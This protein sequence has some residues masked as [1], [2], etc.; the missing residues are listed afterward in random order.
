MP[1]IL[2]ENHRK[3]GTFYKEWYLFTLTFH[4][5]PA[6]CTQKYFRDRL[7]SFRKENPE[8]GEFLNR[9]QKTIIERKLDYC[10]NILLFLKGEAKTNWISPRN[11]L[12]RMF[13]KLFNHDFSSKQAVNYIEKCHDSYLFLLN[14]K[15]KLS[16][17]YEVYLKR[18]KLDGSVIDFLEISL[19]PENESEDWDDY[20]FID[21]IFGSMQE[22]KRY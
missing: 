11:S 13:I 1:P 2:C 18:N 3:I 7:S 19:L 17:D 10:D 12:F 21:L 14:N 15:L 20:Y 4:G 8:F 9:I 22:R 5:A 16:D 6:S